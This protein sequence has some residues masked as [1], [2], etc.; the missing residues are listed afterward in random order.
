[1]DGERLDGLMVSRWEEEESDGVTAV[2]VVGLVVIEM[3]F[4]YH[5][6]SDGEKGKEGAGRRLFQRI[7]IILVAGQM[8]GL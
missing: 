8:S 1:M 4:Y 2:I 5:C 3:A 7:V 6:G